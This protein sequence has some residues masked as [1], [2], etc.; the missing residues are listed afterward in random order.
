MSE[1]KSEILN[2][3]IKMKNSSSGP[4]SSSALHQCAVLL[5]HGLW[6]I[7]DAILHASAKTNKGN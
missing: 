1:S 6:H 2:N 7:G 4:A 3:F 5:F